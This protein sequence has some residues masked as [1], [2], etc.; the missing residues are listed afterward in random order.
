MTRFSADDKIVYQR[1]GRYDCLRTTA[2]HDIIWSIWAGDLGELSW[3]HLNGKWQF[4]A[5]SRELIGAFLA[6]P[7]DWAQGPPQLHAEYSLPLPGSRTSADCRCFQVSDLV[8]QFT[9][10]PSCTILLWQIEIFN[11]N[12]KFLRN[13]HDLVYFLLIFRSWR[14]SSMTHLLTSGA[15]VFRRVFVQKD[16]ILN[17]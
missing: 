13:F 3:A 8:G 9:Q 10:Q 7:L 15:N 2:E 6:C 5:K 4:H 12:R 1:D 14:S 11:Q 16:N 17:I